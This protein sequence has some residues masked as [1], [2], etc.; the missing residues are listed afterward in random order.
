MSIGP[1]LPARSYA[2]PAAGP[3]SAPQRPPPCLRTARDRRTPF[4]PLVRRASVR[5]RDRARESRRAETATPTSS[6]SHGASGCTPQGPAGGTGVLSPGGLR[7]A[8]GRMGGRKNAT[9]LVRIRA[10]VALFRTHFPAARRT[11]PNTRGLY[12]RWR[13][14]KALCALHDGAWVGTRL[15]RRERSRGHGV[16]PETDG[17]SVRCRTVAPGDPSVLVAGRG[18]SGLCYRRVRAESRCGC[19]I[20]IA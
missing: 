18:L 16:R 5:A 12:A 4:R 13:S 8:E 17:R 9:R 11:P 2:L 19:C 6:A 1:D 3:A 14:P 7:R 10:L 15:R 20:V